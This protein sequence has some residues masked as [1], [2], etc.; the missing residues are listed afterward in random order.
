VVIAQPGVYNIQFSAQY[1]AK[2]STNIFI[3]LEQNGATVTYSNTVLHTVAGTNNPQLAAWNW[4]IKTT[5]S[6]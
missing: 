6:K 3:W 4:F 2:N 1:Q 5:D